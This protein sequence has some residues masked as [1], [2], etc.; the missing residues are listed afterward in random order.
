MQVVITVNGPG[1]V[2]GWLTPLAARLRALYPDLS[3]FVCLLPCVFASGREASVIRGLGTVDGV[4]TVRETWRFVLTG[5]RPA[6]MAASGPMLVFH[7]GGEMALTKAIA[8]RLGADI[9]AY[10]ELHR[11]VDG[12]I[13]KV[14]YTGL[15]HRPDDPSLTVGEMM[16]DAAEM[17]RSAAPPRVQ[18]R[19]VLALFPGSRDYMV[20]PLLPYYAAIIDRLA[21]R[22][23]DLEFVVARSDYISD[24]FLRALPVP[25]SDAPWPHSALTLHED[26]GALWFTTAQGTRIDVA[27]G[28]QVVARAD[29]ALTIP[30]TNTGEIAAFGVP[31]V[32]ALPTY[33]DQ[34]IPMPGLLGHIAKIPVLGPAIRRAAGRRF[35]ASMPHLALPNRRANRRIVPEFVGRG[36]D[37]GITQALEDLVSH[38]TTELRAR[39]RDAMGQPGAADRLAR[40]IGT[41]FGL[42]SR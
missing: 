21:P 33:L 3:I 37:A 30:G 18:G 28:P 32:V 34:T 14:F 5:R 36:I 27:P 23:P 13:R 24:A 19:R 35:L 16:V 39:I 8:W 12:R 22:H 38:D 1:E 41:A 42:L 25:P 2:S 10:V 7:L 9:H 17:R 40:H 15:S 4:T 31:M 29:F 20:G 6:G 26:A 11:P